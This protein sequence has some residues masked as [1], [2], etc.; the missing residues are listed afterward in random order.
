MDPERPKAISGT[1]PLKS[2]AQLVA[3]F[4]ATIGS[5]TE[6]DRET[7]Q[8]I[9][10]LFPEKFTTNNLLRALELARAERKL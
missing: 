7:I 10:S 3:D 5:N 4:V 6:L 2:G 9:V 1:E 8:A